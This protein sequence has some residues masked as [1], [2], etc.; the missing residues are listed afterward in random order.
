M[1]ITV[2]FIITRGWKEPRCPSTEGLIKKRWYIYTTKHYSA[3]KNDEFM[4]FLG[5]YME[6]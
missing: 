2:L 4:K 1:F 5:K 3:F 6:L